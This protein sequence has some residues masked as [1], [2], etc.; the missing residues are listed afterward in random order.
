MSASSLGLSIDV[1][2][3]ITRVRVTPDQDG[4]IVDTE[5]AI[6]NRMGE[7]DDIPVSI[8]IPMT[9]PQMRTLA[10]WCMSM[11]R[12]LEQKA[13]KGDSSEHVG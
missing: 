8:D 10:Q 4:L 1:D 6:T 11:A 9:P 3:G 2:Q 12:N 13:L 7:R 5:A